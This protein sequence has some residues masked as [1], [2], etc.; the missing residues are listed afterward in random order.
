MKY[1][2]NKSLTG[3]T[4]LIHFTKGKKYEV[5]KTGLLKRDAIHKNNVTLIDD[6][7]D[8]HVVWEGRN[9]WLKHF[10]KVTE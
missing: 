6:Q 9:H 3:E 8:D 4:A 2:C 5:G 10:T 1:I 7:G